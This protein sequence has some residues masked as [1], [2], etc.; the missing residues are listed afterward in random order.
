MIKITLEK[1]FQQK[2]LSFTEQVEHLSKTRLIKI[3]EVK[4]NRKNFAKVVKTFVIH[5]KLLFFLQ[6]CVIAKQLRSTINYW[7]ST[8]NETEQ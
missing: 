4:K 6:L 1:T 8:I 3:T 5:L 7:A 2:Q